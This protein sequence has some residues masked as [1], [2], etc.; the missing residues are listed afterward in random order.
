MSSSSIGWT[1]FISILWRDYKN[2]LKK[3]SRHN[4]V[5]FAMALCLGL[6]GC[7]AGPDNAPEA[8]ASTA[9]GG[10]AAP[11]VPGQEGPDAPSP[12]P[13]PSSQVSF[14]VVDE[15]GADQ[16]SEVVLVVIDGRSVG[17]LAVNTTQPRDTLRVVVT[18]SGSHT[19]YL[20]SRAMER[21]NGE[22]REL[23][24]EGAG[25]ILVSEDKSFSIYG[26]VSGGRI[27]LELR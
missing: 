7:I 17:E 22:E 27:E 2:G 25:V 10:G 5:I 20:K 19:Y 4:N 3:V 15:L 21:V 11:N 26:T 13:Q 12:S 6:T 9:E 1:V 14:F 8:P 24:G 16:L 23:F 18:S